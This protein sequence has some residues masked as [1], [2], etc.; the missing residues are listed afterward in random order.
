MSIG[1]DYIRDGLTYSGEAGEVTEDGEIILDPKQILHLTEEV[2]MAL[3]AHE[4]AHFYLKHYLTPAEGL[5]QEHEAEEEQRQAACEEPDRLPE[6]PD[7]LF[8]S[9]R[10]DRHNPI[11]GDGVNDAK[12]DE[13]GH[14]G[15]GRA[16]EIAAKEERQ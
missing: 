6:G 14:Q 10:R 15:D 9:P 11:A 13:Q 12:D 7:H 1:F 16:S 4:F 8:D 2:A 3:I 5:E